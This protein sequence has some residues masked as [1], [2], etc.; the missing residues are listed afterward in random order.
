MVFAKVL[1]E[2]CPAAKRS[3]PACLTPEL[4][5]MSLHFVAKPCVSSIEK[6]VLEMAFWISTDK[7]LKV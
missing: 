3:M 5:S 1:E 7:W 6:V 4:H 2:L